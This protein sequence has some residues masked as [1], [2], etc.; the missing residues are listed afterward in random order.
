MVDPESTR[1]YFNGINGAT[2][3][4]LLD[5]LSA[6]VISSVATGEKLDPEEL[7]ELKARV[8]AMTG[9]FLGAAAGIDTKNLAETGWG[10]I[11]AHD[12]DPSLRDA[13]KSLLDHR[14]EQSGKG[15]ET[16][17]REFTGPDGYRPGESS[18]AFLARHKAAPGEPANPVKVPYYLLIVG[19]P[20]KIPYR[21]QYQL[22]VIYATGRVH[23]DT[24]DDYA[25]YAENVVAAEQRERT[26]RQAMFFGVQNQD[27]KATGMSATMLV[28]PLADRLQPRETSWSIDTIIGAGATKAAM[29]TVLGGANPPSLLFSASHGMGFPNGDIRQIEHQGALLCQDWPGPVQWNEA[30]P[31]AFY[32]AADDLP[33]S[34]NL[35]GLV[36][37]LFAC[38]GVGTPKTDD[39]A[40]QALQQAAAIAPHAFVGRLPQKML[41]QGALA[42]AGHVERAWSYSFNWPRAGEQLEA[43]EGTLY[44]A[45]EGFPIGHAIED[46]NTK[47]AALTTDLE[48]EKEN[49]AFGGVPDPV[50]LS[51]L[52]TAKNDARNY[53][54]LGD[55]AAR[56]L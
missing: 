11:F 56:V 34:A 46:F 7:A 14:K 44:K 16:F 19:D 3:R 2:G 45:M 18:S 55:P 49:I 47:Y 32:F 1:L 39:F 8:M 20:E 5:P 6:D 30:I 42:V 51:G 52:W 17:Y 40:R 23:F 4:Y 33:V 50:G 13:L 31:E 53:V 35:D 25:T 43:F 41:L 48:S 21:F 54:I 24:P 26:D 9:L 10:V 27:D 12:A 36:T 22:D 28:G 29:G 15:N 37:F 38:Y